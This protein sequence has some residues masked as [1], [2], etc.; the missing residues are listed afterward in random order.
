MEE[1]GQFD[2]VSALAHMDTVLNFTA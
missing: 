1:S 2:T